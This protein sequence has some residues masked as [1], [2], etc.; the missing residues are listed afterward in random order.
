LF[1]AGEMLG[2]ILLSAHNI[3]YYQ[4]LLSDARAAIKRGRYLDFLRER[5]LDW[6]E[7]PDSPSVTR[8]TD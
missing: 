8:E 4:R 2:P 6:R 7:N 5:V 3:T 1:M